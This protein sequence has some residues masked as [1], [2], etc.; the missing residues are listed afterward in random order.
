[1]IELQVHERY[2]NGKLH[3]KY[4]RIHFLKNCFI[5]RSHIVVF[6]AFFLP[7]SNFFFLVMSWT[8]SSTLAQYHEFESIFYLLLNLFNFQIY[9]KKS[10]LPIA[11]RVKKSYEEGH[12][13][14]GYELLK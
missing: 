8:H 14:P 7:K 2:L 9:K 6:A 4:I 1:M 10:Y 13:D 12:G 5:F 11:G 3:T